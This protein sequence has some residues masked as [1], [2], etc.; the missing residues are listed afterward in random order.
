MLLGKQLSSSLSSGD[1]PRPARDELTKIIHDGSVQE[2][3]ASD[4]LASRQV[5]S[6]RQFLKYAGM[7][8][9]A[10]AAATA[11]I[12]YLT[13]GAAPGPVS[14]IAKACRKARD[15]YERIFEDSLTAKGAFP[16]VAFSPSGKFDWTWGDNATSSTYPATLRNRHALGDDDALDPLPQYLKQMRFGDIDLTDMV[17]LQWSDINNPAIGRFYEAQASKEY[18]E[19][20]GLLTTFDHEEQATIFSRDRNARTAQMMVPRMYDADAH[21]FVG[22]MPQP[23]NMRLTA[24]HAFYLYPL[25]RQGVHRGIDGLLDP[26]SEIQEPQ[27]DFE[28]IMLQQSPLRIT[29]LYD[30]VINSSRLLAELTFPDGRSVYKAR[31]EPG[32]QV[33]GRTTSHDGDLGAGSED[34]ATVAYTH[35]RMLRGLTEAK[36]L[37]HDLQSTGPSPVYMAMLKA[38][39]QFLEER[40]QAMAGL[41]EKGLAVRLLSQQ[42]NNGVLPEFLYRSGRPELILEYPDIA[43][44]AGAIRPL[45]QLGRERAARSVMD[46]LVALG[47]AYL[48]EASLEPAPVVGILPP[49]SRGYYPAWKQCWVAFGDDALLDAII[50]YG[51]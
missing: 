41:L 38:N 1:P 23:K 14:F 9:A 30:L 4:D 12:S 5:L 25:L 49:A 7:G 10:V 6:R 11:G 18:L 34:P 24:D 17:S 39:E 19:E 44:T 35:V 37:H 2:A 13:Q 48:D 21:A 40:C 32:R 22:I 31:I 20:R 16:H 42:L 15:D 33:V 27:D 26:R 45:M 28:M 43:S 8:A 47:G 46:T 36:L 3:S 51:A 50:R 29:E